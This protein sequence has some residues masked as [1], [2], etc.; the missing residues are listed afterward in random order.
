MTTPRG[1][2]LLGLAIGLLV[3]AEAN[4]Q[5][6]SSDFA[7]GDDGWVTVGNN[8]AP[9]RWRTGEISQKDE[10]RGIMCFRAP[11]KY[12]GDQSRAYGGTLSF[13]MSNSAVRY[14]PSLPKV[15]ITAQTPAGTLRLVVNLPRPSS[16]SVFEHYTI[17]LDEAAGWRLVGKGRAPTSEEFQAVL[18]GITDLR[19]VGE[20]TSQ[21]GE[22]FALR[23]IRIDGKDLPGPDLSRLKVYVLAG[24]SNMAGCDDVRNVDPMWRSEFADVMMYWGNDLAPAF[25][26]LAPGTSGATCSNAGPQFF[27]GPEL[28]F[29]SEV[30]LANPNEQVV[31]IKF[32]VGGTSMYE[33]WTTPTGEYPQGGV[34]WNQLQDV[35]GEAFT[36]LGEM[37]YEYD[38]EAFLWMQGESDA[39]KRYRARA[40]AGNL[41]SFI[42]SMRTYVGDPELPFILGRIRD[43]GQPHAETV[44]EAQVSV[45]MNTPG[46]Y[47]FDTDDLAFLPDGI[48]YDEPGMIELGH[49]F[50]DIV[51]SLP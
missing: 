1:F 27:F 15:W 31:I 22:V 40:Y 32:A 47:W 50:A 29:G 8:N 28:A 49:R 51:L 16:P 46:V 45:A 25:Q 48:H 42:A 41:S 12:L 43:A 2:A 30:A 21:S 13:E 24:Q 5:I 33:Y 11:A 38:V 44:R 9:T 14:A 10:Y 19:I 35:M 26:S 18:A 36:A 39:D 7:L 34:L 23:Q 4:A 3:A 37:G 17:G 6:V 20:T